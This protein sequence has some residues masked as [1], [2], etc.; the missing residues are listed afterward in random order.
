MC[1]FKKIT[2]LNLCTNIIY[3]CLRDLQMFCS[4]LLACDYRAAISERLEK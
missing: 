4:I 1:M 2:I 3:S